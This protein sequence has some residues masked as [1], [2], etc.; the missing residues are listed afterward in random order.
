M[1]LCNTAKQ[2]SRGYSIVA[3]SVAPE[4]IWSNEFFG[5]MISQ[6]GLEN[7]V[8]KLG[9][10]KFTNLDNSA[11]SEQ[12]TGSGFNSQWPHFII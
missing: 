4:M 2:Y 9:T 8:L 3:V 7:E 1:T 5:T 11:L 6:R 12:T 10:E